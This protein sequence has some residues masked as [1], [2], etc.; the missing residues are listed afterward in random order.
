MFLSL[1]W[2]LLHPFVFRCHECSFSRFRLV[3]GMSLAA[4]SICAG[5]LYLE[6]VDPNLDN[7]E[8]DPYIEIPE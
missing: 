1:L 3:G 8:K 4:S 2:L 7:P 6:T 5:T